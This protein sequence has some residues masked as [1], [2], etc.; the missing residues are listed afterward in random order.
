MLFSQ[1]LLEKFYGFCIR[2]MGKRLFHNKYQPKQINKTNIRGTLVYSGN[3]AA[4][5]ADS[6]LCMWYKS[7]NRWH[8]DFLFYEFVLTYQSS[9]PWLASTSSAVVR[10][11]LLLRL[12]LP[13]CAYDRS[14]GTEGQADIPSRQRLEW[15]SENPP[16][17]WEIN[18]QIA[19]IFR[20]EAFVIWRGI[21]VFNI[22]CFSV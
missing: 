6:L 11:L 13:R 8:G 21:Y 15:T 14:Q 12:S 7:L 3:S 18:T 2:L 17:A 1:Y 22:I 16:L 9:H 4:Q 19:L 5:V 20:E 10:I